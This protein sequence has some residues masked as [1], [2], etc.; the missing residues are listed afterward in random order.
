MFV[1]FLS[2]VQFDFSDFLYVEILEKYKIRGA[3]QF[4]VSF[5][6]SS[7]TLWESLCFFVIKQKD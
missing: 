6:A 3:Y 1:C 5:L 4:I 2:N 7:M